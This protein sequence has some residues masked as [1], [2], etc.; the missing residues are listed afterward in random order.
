MSVQAG[1]PGGGR[2]AAVTAGPLRPGN[3]APKH[4][5]GPQLRETQKGRGA[6]GTGRRAAGRPVP[7]EGRAEGG[8][9][10]R[11][12]GALT[13]ARAEPGAPRAGPLSAHPASPRPRE[14]A[15]REPTGLVRAPWAAGGTGAH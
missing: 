5:A 15:G 1:A 3:G 4:H 9:G 14:N 10:A 12:A 13:R 8:L 6:G 11:W 2:S 7:L